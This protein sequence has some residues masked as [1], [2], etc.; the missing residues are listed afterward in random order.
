[1]GTPVQ[2]QP[3]LKRDVKT[4]IL[5]VGGGAA[6]LAAALRVMDSGLDV[7]LIDRSICGGSS[8]GK[9]AGFLTPDSELELSQILRRFGP[10]GARDLWECAQWGVNRMV[11]MIRDHAIE[12]DL[13]KQDSL[14]LGEG[15]SGNKEVSL[16]LLARRSMGYDVEGFTETELSSLIGAVGFTGAVRYKQT[17]G[18]NGLRYAQ[19][20]K[21]IL[22]D[23]GVHVHEST[24]AIGLRDHTV[25]T[26]LG[27]ATAENI[28]FAADKLQQNLSDHFWNYYYAQ[29]F[30]AM[31]EP[32][33]AD[34]VKAMFP[35]D[36]FL[37]W[38]SHFIY[39]YW[40]LT[41][42]YRILLG[43]GSLWTT[44][45]KKDVWTAR[46]IDR[47][48]RRFR[49]HWPSVRRVH[50]RQFWMG[51]ID[52]TRDLL[53]TVLR[54]PTMP[55]VHYVL[56]CLGLPWATFCG[57]FVARHVLNDQT[58]DDHRFYRY[59]GIDRGFAV[60]LW[61]EMILGKRIAFVLNQAYAKYRQIDTNKSSS[62]RPEEF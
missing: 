50:F 10:K 37:C 52:M 16:E 12:A 49:E 1:M 18:V 8:T 30:L 41:G 23:H 21:K 28:I 54:E 47:V 55:W 36:P 4:D 20:V 33:R 26:H 5:I 56:G 13:L 60:P 53:P 9:S 31:S 61:A 42:D 14:F 34:E 39:A 17:Y 45:A 40:R 29:T 44:Y 35:V 58:Q 43:G 59:F 11:N 2:F 22:L 46:I 7:T 32:L 38:D 6:G 15:H 27:S 25:R 57:D 48:I 51:R 19:G 24:E 62:E 3:P